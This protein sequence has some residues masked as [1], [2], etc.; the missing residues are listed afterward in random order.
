MVSDLLYR[1][2]A[3]FRRNSMEAELDEE[4]RAH[5]EHQVEKYVQSGMSREEAERRAKIE[6]GGLDQVKEEC[7]DAWGVRFIETLLQ[8]LRFAVRML[9]RNP[10][11]TAVA[12]LSLALGI[13]ANT[14]I[15]SLLDALLLR[16]LPVWQPERLVEFS[17]IRRGDKI[18]FSFP[19]LRELNQGQKVFSGLIGWTPGYMANLEFNG[20]LSQAYVG[21]VTG[22]YYSVLGTSPLLGRLINPDDVNLSGAVKSPVAVLSYEFWQHR[23]GGTSDVLG[24]EIVV[25]GQPFTVIGVARRWFAGMA[26]GEPADVTIPIKG[27]DERS[28]LWVSITGRLKDGVS[29]AQ[30][31]AQLQSFWPEVLEAT[32]STATPGLRRQTFLSMGLDVVSAAT[33]VNAKLRSRFTRPLSLLMAIVGLILLLACVNLASLM[34]ARAAARS[35]ETSVR[36]ALGA[37]RWALAR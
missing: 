8:D 20:V 24:K 2:R 21:S 13:G 10:G 7:R 11:F 34:L 18:P 27:T 23:F 16:D 25:D 5:L 30:A 14:A 37:S 9:A 4:L 29:I 22:N 31:R 33:G 6:F 32:A 3:L 28:R 1:L 36:V 17:V 19:M 26:T 12:V 35:H 15:F